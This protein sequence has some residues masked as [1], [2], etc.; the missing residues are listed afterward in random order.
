M[1]FLYSMN[2]LLFSTQNTYFLVKKFSYN[3]LFPHVQLSPCSSL[4]RECGGLSV[5]V[6]IENAGSCMLANLIVAANW[7]HLTNYKNL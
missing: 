2:F 7:L 6:C 3:V 1:I 5:S 4:L